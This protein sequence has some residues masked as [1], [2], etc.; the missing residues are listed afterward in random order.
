MFATVVLDASVFVAAARR[1]EDDHTASRDV[2]AELIA[3]GARLHMPTIVIPEVT[4]ALVRRGADLDAVTDLMRVIDSWP[5]RSF[6]VVDV[7]L[8]ERA[9]SLAAALGLRGCDAVYVA[10]AAMLDATLITLD[11]AQRQRLPP[12]VAALTPAEALAQLG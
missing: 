1:I 12:G 5:G 10:L 6:E 9:A 3:G 7:D 11:L 4:A 8:A 2:M